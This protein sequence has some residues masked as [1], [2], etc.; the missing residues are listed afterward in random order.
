[1]HTYTAAA[2]AAAAAGCITTL[3]TQYSYALR[4][5]YTHYTHY[6]QHTA[7]PGVAPAL[8]SQGT[9]AARFR[10]GAA[11]AFNAAVPP[12]IWAV[13]NKGGQF[14]VST[15]DPGFVITPARRLQSSFTVE[16]FN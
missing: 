14:P 4:T 6:Y 11:P 3:L 13:S 5:T 7:G 1:L 8:P 2:A 16:A 12:L 10:A 15:S 9:W